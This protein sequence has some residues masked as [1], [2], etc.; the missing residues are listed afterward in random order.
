MK[1][2][3][4]HL[5]ESFGTNLKKIRNDKKLSLRALAAKCD[6]DDSQISKIE[7]ATW[8]VQLSTIFELAKGLEVEPKDLLDFKI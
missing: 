6:L 8:D 2:N 7:N 5:K 4:D 3:Y 1:S